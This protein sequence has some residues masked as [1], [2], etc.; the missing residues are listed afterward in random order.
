MVLMR[1]QNK[2][3]IIQPNIYNIM[4]MEN[5]MNCAVQFRSN[6]NLPSDLKGKKITG[7]ARLIRTR[8][9]PSTTLFKVS[10]K[11]FPI[12]FLSCHV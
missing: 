10:V 9:I 4:N 3:K 6:F 1:N 11:C 2:W 8:L 5:M 7:W 12:I